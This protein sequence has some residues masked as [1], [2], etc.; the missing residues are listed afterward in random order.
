MLRNVSLSLA[1][2]LGTALLVIPGSPAIASTE[3]CTVSG[4]QSRALSGTSTPFV[5][6]C[7]D[8]VESSYFGEYGIFLDGQDFD[9]VSVNEYDSPTTLIADVGNVPDGSHTLTFESYSDSTGGFVTQDIGISVDNATYPATFTDK[10]TGEPV[11]DNDRLV[12]T[13]QIRIDQQLELTNQQITSVTLKVPGTS[14]DIDDQLAPFD[15]LIDTS[16]IQD[17][18]YAMNAT[19]HLSDKRKRT[20]SR[21]FTVQ[22]DQ[23][24][25]FLNSASVKVKAGRSVTVNG[26][27]YDDTE[28]LGIGSM[29]VAL[30]AGST[31]AGARIATVTTDEQGHFSYK[32]TPRAGGSLVVAYGGAPGQSSALSEVFRWAVKT[33]IHL[34]T[35]QK[36]PSLN[37]RIRL[38]VHVLPASAGLPVLMQE[39]Y[40]SRWHT[41]DTF[42]TGP[43]GKRTIRCHFTRS[44]TAYLRAVL[45]HAPGLLDSESNV[46]KERIARDR[47]MSLAYSSWDTQTS[48]R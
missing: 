18:T 6:S 29:T 45:H 9:G 5:V 4:L 2:L 30:R 43:G 42:S 7:T 48:F 20:T 23:V 12:G 1:L 37:E 36:H 46:I 8:E 44:G 41:F 22:N 27:L 39:F 17:G 38:R 34:T 3:A 11:Q 33:H 32:F 31:A 26:R 13:E 21:T 10:A 16:G 25:V 35:S 24:E 15:F 40:R 47:R 28:S 14:I 19:V